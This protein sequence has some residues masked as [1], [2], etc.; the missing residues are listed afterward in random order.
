MTARR[1]FTIFVTVMAVAL[2]AVDGC[3][4]GGG[5]RSGATTPEPTPLPQ[6]SDGGGGAGVRAAPSTTASMVNPTAA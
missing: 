6:R 3:A 1:P 5:A 2:G 4:L